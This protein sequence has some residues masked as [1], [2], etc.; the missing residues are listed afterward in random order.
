MGGGLNSYGF[1]SGDRV[2]FSDPFGLSPCAISRAWTECLAQSAADWGARRG[3]TLG[4]LAL[5]LAA[6]ANAGMEA[7]GV[8]MAAESGDRLGSGELGSGMAL[9]AFTFGPAAIGKGLRGASVGLRALFQE[10]GGLAD[11]TIIGIRSTLRSN[12]FA[13]RLA[14]NKS[15]YLFTNAAGEE[16][17]VMRGEAGW[18]LRVKNQAGNYLDVLGNPGNRA[19]T[20]M[21]IANQ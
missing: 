4:G 20:H 16:V 15:G 14:E 9:A 13:M 12:G 10:A 7:F 1:A 8:N 3:G 11:G 17:R 18:Y 2:S 19:S 21:P 6:A 5:N